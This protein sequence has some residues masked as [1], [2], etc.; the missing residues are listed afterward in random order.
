MRFVAIGRRSQLPPSLLSSM[1]E[2]RKD[3]FVRR[4]G[5]S[6]QPI[7]YIDAVEHDEYDTVDAVYLMLH[8]ETARVTACARLLA[9]TGPYMLREHFPQ[10][11]GNT[12]PPSDPAIWELSRFATTVH[13]GN[14]GRQFSLCGFT[15]DLL[16]VIFDA[17]R[18]RSVQRLILVTSVAVERLLIRARFEAHRMAPPGSV[19]GAL[20]VALL[21][22]VPA[23][24]SVAPA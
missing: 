8:D 14:Q 18:K 2:L 9:S 13:S 10:L 11:L 1:Q 20:C 16:N 7:P 15:Q 12:A 6:L 5:W 19:E 21:I 17:A 22:E 4:R 23:A 24:A 3:V